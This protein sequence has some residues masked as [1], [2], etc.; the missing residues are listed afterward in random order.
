MFIISYTIIIIIYCI[1]YVVFCVGADENIII[2]ETRTYLP[3][4][5]GT[6]YTRVVLLEDALLLI[7]IILYNRNNI[8]IIIQNIPKIYTVRVNYYFRIEYNAHR[9]NEC[10]E[11]CCFTHTAGQC[12]SRLLFLNDFSVY[13]FT[14]G[15]VRKNRAPPFRTFY[16][17]Y[18]L[19][20]TIAQMYTKNNYSYVSLNARQ[21]ESEG[22]ILFP[23]RLLTRYTLC[24]YKLHN[25][26]TTLAYLERVRVPEIITSPSEPIK[27]S[28]QCGNEFNNYYYF[29]KTVAFLLL[30]YKYS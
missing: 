13:Y 4:M 8:I 22:I 28:L 15:F 24:Y 1:I 3:K 16:P 27:G 26:I 9:W 18:P 5:V 20:V 10:R 11:H 7:H 17:F 6:L 23:N 29:S 14:V 21:R 25:I 30:Q 19:P 2:F 12:I